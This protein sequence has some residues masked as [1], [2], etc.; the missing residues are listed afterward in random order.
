MR[1]TFAPGCGNIKPNTRIVRSLLFD[2]GQ[3][4]V[5]SRE[6]EEVENDYDD[7]YD[8]EEESERCTESEGDHQVLVSSE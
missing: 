8:S 7:Y 6:W 1:G 5:E 3:R 4:R 2:E